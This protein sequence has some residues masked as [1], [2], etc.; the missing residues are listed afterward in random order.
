MTSHTEAW[1]LFDWLCHRSP[2]DKAHRNR[3]QI[4]GV[5]VYLCRTA[6][7]TD[8]MALLVEADGRW[9]LHTSR[10]VV[11][12]DGSHRAIGDASVTQRPR[13]VSAIDALTHYYDASEMQGL[14]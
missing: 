10:C 2:A 13:S 11:L 12:S 7:A 1:V 4:A 14:P 9:S 6:D 5:T 8:T 3:T